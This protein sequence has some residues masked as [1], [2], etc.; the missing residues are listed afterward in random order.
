MSV[1]VLDVLLEF[2]R[3]GEWGSGAPEDGLVEVGIIRGTDF[4]AV[5]YG[6]ISS[7]PIR[8]VRTSVVEK[9]KLK[10]GDV[11]IETAGGTKD[12]PTGRSVFLNDRVLK[13]N[14]RPLL[15]ASFA[16]FLRVRE[17][18][19][20]PQFLFWKLQDEYIREELRPYHIQHTGVARFQYTQFANT[21]KLSFPDSV[22]EQ[23]AIASILSALDDKIELNRRMNETLEALAQAIFK[24]W[25]VDFGP[26]R[27][28]A[29]GAADPVA[30]LGNLIP[31][32]ARAQKTA[33][34]F[35][36]TFN[37]DGLPDG[38]TMASLDSFARASSSTIDPTAI[39]PSTPYIGLEHMPRKSIM[40]DDWGKSGSVTSN[41]TKFEKGQ[42][43]FGKLRPYF[44]KV[45]IAPVDGVS[46]TD[47][48]I[49]DA[50][51]VTDRSL[52]V[53]CVSTD[54]FV[55]FTDQ[56]SDGTK[57]PRTSWPKMKQY[58]VALAS[59]P[60]RNSFSELAT[61]LHEKIVGS[62][63]ENRTLAET[64]DYLLPKLMSGE[65]RVGDVEKLVEGASA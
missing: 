23:K 35:P 5:R 6:D 15:C 60:V 49:L 64:R 29:E 26:T 37:D 31:D 28:K 50:K 2:T 24:D 33:A 12:Q 3:D 61:P 53:C 59:E 38:W 32:K 42:I 62:I 41:K 25:F 56:G 57:M 14:S 54:H 7:I 4:N 48:I 45:G 55:A 39:D 43:L 34:L 11:L 9:K 10:A 21:H 65:V 27:R 22:A 13:S 58:A 20:D 18:A 36:A 63:A 19:I 1:S 30:I 40:L 52:V 47:I 16:R 17:G 44:H 46:S 8:Y 51:S